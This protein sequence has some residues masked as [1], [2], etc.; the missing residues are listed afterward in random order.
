[1]IAKIKPRKVY[2]EPETVDNYIS[3]SELSDYI[4]SMPPC[5]EFKPE[6]FYNREGDMIEVYFENAS[7][8]AERMGN[9]TV[10][11]SQ[12]DNRIVG[13]KIHGVKSLIGLREIK[14]TA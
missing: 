3:L 11:R 8:Y 7:C 14:V 2:E 9:F 10:E 1:M 13:V 12:H 6:A 5:G 4:K